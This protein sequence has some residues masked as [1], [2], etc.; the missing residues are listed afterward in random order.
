M[1]FMIG[2]KPIVVQ[3]QDENA[4]GILSKFSFESLLI[5]QYDSIEAAQADGMVRRDVGVLLV[6]IEDSPAYE[7]GIRAG[8]ILL[9]VDLSRT[10]EPEDLS[11][12][13]AT[14]S[15]GQEVTLHVIR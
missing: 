7:A 10:H 6:P 11:N 14:Y 4:S 8:D 2:T 13:L 5:P 3:I 9:G 12:I 1:V 15:P